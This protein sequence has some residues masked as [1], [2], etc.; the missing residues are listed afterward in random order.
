MRKPALRFGI[1]AAVAVVFAFLVAHPALAQTNQS[2]S[3]GNWLLSI[4]SAVAMYVAE[5]IGKF[6]IAILDITI[7]LMRY[8]G[9]TSSPVVSAGW[10]VV[11]DVVNMFF[12]VILIIIAM[13][14]IFGSSRFQWKQQVPRLM[15]F[16]IVINFSKTLCGIMI[17]FAQVVM[18]TFA[19]ALKDIAGGNFIQLLGLG[20]IFSLSDKADAIAQSAAGTGTGTGPF[21]Y[22]VASVAAVF[23][24]VW[25][26]AVVIMLL[27]I[28]V[29]RVVM[30]WILIVLAP[31]AWFLGGQSVLKSGA[32]S[33][34]E[35]WKNFICYTAIGPV[36]TFFLWLT[37]AVAGSGFIAANDP[38]LSSL[39]SGGNLSS[40]VSNVVTK[41]FEFQR[42][43]SFVIGMAMMMVGFDAAAKIC[44]GV[45]KAPGFDKIMGM[46]KGVPGAIGGYVGGRVSKY[47]GKGLAAGFAGAQSAVSGTG[48]GLLA[49]TAGGAGFAA[50]APTKSGQAKRAEGLRNLS[51]KGWM[52]TE[53]STS[54]ATSADARQADL[55]KQ[56]KSA[57][58]GTF[59]D[60]SAETKLDYLKKIA[61]DGRIPVGQEATAMGLFAEAIKDPKMREKMA[62]AG[63]LDKM[64]KSKKDGGMEMGATLKSY[65]RNTPD[66]K[67]L[68]EFEEGRPDLTGN[69]KGLNSM[70]DVEKLDPVALA[71]LRDEMKRKTALGNEFESRMK[72]IKSNTKQKRTNPAT[73]VEEVVTLSALEHYDAGFG[74]VKKQKAW[75]D[76]MSGVY[77]GMSNLTLSQVPV[78][79]L[80]ANATPDI[81]SRRP[82]VAS[83]VVKNKGLADGMR[84]GKPAAYRAV[85]AQAFGATF[86]PSGKMTGIDAAKMKA[87]M[88]S[89]P[90][91][92]RSVAGDVEG[93]EVFGRAFIGALDKKS[94]GGITKE[95][96]NAD[97]DGREALELGIV[98]SV[99]EATDAVL[100]DPGSSAE[101]RATA[102]K[103]R[104]AVVRE[105]NAANFNTAYE[106]LQTKIDALNRVAAGGGPGAAAASAKIAKL[107]RLQNAMPTT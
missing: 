19:N 105:I 82:D 9:F 91:V 41:V 75:S 92:A 78:A 64:Y 54:L 4:F 52:P 72:A 77:E 99:I 56:L 38:G 7:P 88:A 97:D 49:A 48:A 90:G 12:V 13:G 68:D 79:D 8:Q 22:F 86:D 95:Y 83:H 29:Y 103:N 20:D 100:S 24:M 31:L 36:I 102:S 16:A 2:L 3:T 43:L 35:W 81:V 27:F 60:A 15:I 62:A 44:N 98:D 28:L 66:A 67:A 93:N 47:G 51:K 37:L 61:S 53:V 84:T 40:N 34:E 55:A 17:D 23:M 46:G 80:A 96:K 50:L 45:K 11:R 74:S 106:Y 18:L 104:D 58:E 76:G 42:L 33:Y 21:D 6:V 14:T 25:V 70:D 87:A 57:A 5:A 63:I 65:V 73:G 85:Q 26:L 94:I 107:Q 10:A 71:R 30:L 1:I 89:D 59:K 39:A 69:L 101:A 32:G